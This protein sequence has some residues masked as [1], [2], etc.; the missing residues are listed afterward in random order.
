MTQSNLSRDDL[1]AWLE[2]GGK[3]A[4]QWRIGTEH[5]KLGFRLADHRPLFYGGPAGIR[6]VLE[7]MQRFGWT[8]VH[9][10]GQIIGLTGSGAD[11]LSGTITLEPGGQFELSGAPLQNL[12]QT[13]AE[14]HAHLAQTRAVGAQLGVGFLGIGFAPGWRRWEMPAMP[15]ARYRIMSRVMT[16]TGTRGLDMMYRS[17]TVQVNLDFA[18]EADMVRKMRLGLALQPVAT[19]LFA[20]SPFCDGKLSGLLSTRAAVWQETDPA[21]TGPLPFAFEDGFGFERYTDY[22]L[23]VPMYFLRRNGRYLDAGQGSFRDFLN[24][25][26]AAAPGLY[27]QIEDW[28]DHLTTLFPEV[29]LKRFIEMRG[30]DGGAGGWI[31][32]LPALWTGLLYDPA[33]CDAAWD[34]VKNWSREERAALHRNCFRRGLQTPFRRESVRDLA[35]RMIEI[36]RAGLRARAAQDERGRDET[37]F[38]DPLAEAVESGRNPAEQ[39]I[40]LYRKEWGADLSGVFQACAY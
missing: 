22:A 26:L 33:A 17:C 10:D 24:G 6:A 12:H 3:P 36:A 37:L 27:P 7:A 30:A 34:M 28:E 14:A 39:L 21:R 29:R 18:A 19:A 15:K 11:G 5:E 16:R 23:D 25:K 32:A 9:E 38:L 20:N 40:A 2:A 8:P 4:A 13:C 1:V 35:R 31:C